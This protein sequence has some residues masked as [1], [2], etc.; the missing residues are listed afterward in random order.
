MSWRFG[1]KIQNVYRDNTFSF[2]R[3]LFVLSGYLF[4]MNPKARLDSG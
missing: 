4:W 1:K 2:E 3:S